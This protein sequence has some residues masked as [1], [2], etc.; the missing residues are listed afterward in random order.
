MTRGWQVNTMKDIMY[1][2]IILHNMI[3]E[4]E[5]DTYD[6]NFE[7]SS[8][9]LDN[10]MSTILVTNGHHFDFEKYLESRAHMHQKE[11]HRQHHYFRTN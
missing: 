5:Y 11:I 8:D 3:V 6:V 2:C 7:H 10:G 9:C 4:D 1:A